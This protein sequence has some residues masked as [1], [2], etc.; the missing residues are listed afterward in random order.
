MCQGF[1]LSATI[2]ANTKMPPVTTLNESE[3]NVVVC[4]FPVMLI[5]MVGNVLERFQVVGKVSSKT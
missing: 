5:M 4:K 1:Y 3:V 2:A